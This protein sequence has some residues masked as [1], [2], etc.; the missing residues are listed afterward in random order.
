MLL[1]NEFLKLFKLVFGQNLS[2]ID[3]KKFQFYNFFS[4]RNSD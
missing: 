4:C 2:Q 3:Q 1:F